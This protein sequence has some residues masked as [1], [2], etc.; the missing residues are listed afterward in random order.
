M[1]KTAP[2]CHSWLTFQPKSLANFKICKDKICI[3]QVKIFV[4]QEL[5]GATIGHYEFFL[6]GRRNDWV[7]PI[8]SK[9]KKTAKKKVNL[10]TLE[11][12]LPVFKASK[13]MSI[14][15]KVFHLDKNR[16]AKIT[17]LLVA[18]VCTVSWFDQCLQTI[19]VCTLGIS[20]QAK[21]IR[22]ASSGLCTKRCTL[23]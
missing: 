9:Q 13:Q 10:E 3:P 22:C 5:L 6:L 18:V 21:M 23:W 20:H 17:S 11:A 2:L 8:I 15:S 7:T 4:P 12:L 19:C 16:K 14:S 1:Q